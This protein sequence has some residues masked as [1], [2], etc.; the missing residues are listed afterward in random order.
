MTTDIQQQY[1][2]I[3]DRKLTI[4]D[5]SE[6]PDLAQKAETRGRNDLA[7]VYRFLNCWFS[8]SP[9]IEVQTSGSTGTPK[10]LQVEKQCMINSAV[11]T[12]KALGLQAGYSALL[13]MDLRYIGAQMMVVRALTAG[14]RLKVQPAQSHPMMSDKSVS[15]FVAIVP[16]QLFHTLQDDEETERLDRCRT[17]IVGGGSVDPALIQHL[18]TLHC[19]VYST[20]GMTETLSHIALKHLN[21]KYGTG[22]HYRPLPGICL[23]L[24]TRH[25]LTVEAP[26]ICKKILETNDIAR[27]YNDGTFDIIGRIDYVI[28]SGGVKIHPEETEEK[29]RRYISFPFVLTAVPDIR[30]GE[31]LVLLIEDE[32][33]MHR[34][35]NRDEV[36]R[37]LHLLHEVLPRYHAPKHIVYIDRIPTTGNTKTDRPACRKI[38]LRALDK[39]LMY[40]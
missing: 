14:L 30:L 9:T 33:A 3:E 2:W 17:V 6:Y 19:N 36:Q 15:D 18:Q 12:C 37:L 25:T 8:A 11:A 23:S 13:T 22:G 38:V 4:A 1:L 10:R 7:D 31:A 29:I 35:D 5:R 21:G 24:S 32:T 40:S 26:E 27:I 28:N 34:T 16:L 20:Y 39:K